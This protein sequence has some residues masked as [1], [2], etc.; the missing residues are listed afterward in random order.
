MD[1]IRHGTT[2]LI[3]HHASPN[4]IEGSLDVIADAA[5]QAGVR[6]ACAYEVTDR[7]GAGRAAA[8]I[9]ENVRF[10]QAQRQRPRDLI[11]AS[12]G[13]HASFA[14]SE[15]TLAR[16]VEAARGAGSGF[17]VHIAEDKADQADS[18]KNYG[19]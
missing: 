1:S 12:F 13:L 16:S 10:I 8:G 3:D 11:G 15:Q 5:V 17:H 7:D 14:L 4:E 2:S 18:L 6:V 19:L 9:H